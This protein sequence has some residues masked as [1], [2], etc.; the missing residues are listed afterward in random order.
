MLDLLSTWTHEANHVCPASRTS[1]YTSI[2]VPSQHNYV[3]QWLQ[4]TEQIKFE[5]TITKVVTIE[6]PT[7]L[8]NLVQFAWNLD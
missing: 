4:I 2:A 8:Y 7:T 1:N 6:G 5:I 3:Y